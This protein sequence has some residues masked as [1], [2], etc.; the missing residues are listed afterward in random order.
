MVTTAAG[1][2]LEESGRQV[3]AR[4]GRAGLVLFMVCT[5]IFMLMLDATV[6]SAALADIRDDFDSSID[7]LQW[8]I[9][10]Y[11]LPLAGLLLTLATAGDRYGRKRVFLGGMAVFT[12]ASLALVLSGTIVQLNALRAVQGVGAAMLFATALPLL[13]AAYP[14]AEARARAIGVYGAVMAG[15]TVAGPVLGGALVTAFGWRSIFTINVPIGVVIFGLAL[16]RMPETARS[17]DRRTDWLGSVLLSGGL[18]AGVLALTRGNSLGWTSSTT[19]AL[20][21]AA[22]VLLMLFPLWQLRATQP[23][24]D[25]SMVRKPGFAGVAVVAVAHMATL[26]AASNYLAVFLINSMGFSPLQMGLRLVPISVSALIAA[27]LA[28]ILAKRIPTAVSMP[29]TMGLVALGMWLLGNV[30]SS[31]SWTH[32]VPGMIIGG[33]GLGAITTVSQAAA[34]T[35]ASQENAGMAS[36]TFGTLRQVGMAMGV[37]GLGAMFSHSARTTAGDGLDALESAR[38]VTVPPELRTRFLDGVAAGAGDDLA[39]AVPAEFAS[40]TPQLADTAH[41]ASVEGLNAL[42]TLG[43]AIGLTATVVAAVLFAVGARMPTAR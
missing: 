18:V 1:G 8:V 25:V 40:A 28:A 19:V 11:A 24:F 3:G 10:A 15:A 23:L 12:G 16:I 17:T 27:P 13:A 29:V 26:M 5:A 30:E 7:G 4:S 2:V 31:D 34:L 37:A 43:T 36:A 32:F 38:N 9:D 33:I 35:F 39:A 20:A 42:F 6:V 41:A 22:L 21:T 14:A